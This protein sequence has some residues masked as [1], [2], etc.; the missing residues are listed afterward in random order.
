MSL[1]TSLEEIYPFLSV[2][3]DFELSAFMPYLEQATR[4]ELQALLGKE[5]LGALMDEYEQAAGDPQAMESKL[6]ALLL[7]VQR[8]LCFYAYVRFA[9]TSN[10]TLSHQGMFE[11]S[12]EHTMSA[13]KWKIQA[14]LLDLIA[15]GDE[16]A[17]SL[18][19]FLEEHA[20]DYPLWK[21][22]EAFSYSDGS[23][24]AKAEEFSHF[25]DINQS[26]R[27]FLRLKPYIRRAEILAKKVLGTE[28]FTDLH[29]QL[30]AQSVSPEGEELL[31]YVRAY[32]AHEAMLRALPFLSF[33][34]SASG[35]QII[36]TI[37]QINVKSAL[38][39]TDRKELK[40]EVYTQLEE[41]RR[42]LIQFLEEH[43]ANYP[44]WGNSAANSQRQPKTH[45]R[46]TENKP[47]RGYIGF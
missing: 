8:P 31:V 22:S 11:Q 35:L 41:A 16:A 44:L 21:D 30:S 26:R 4:K 6:A 34:Q 19:A 5:L 27:L 2:D 9:N 28:Q 25:I 12:P 39:A 18:I 20:D 23:L 13:P 47:D 10:L 37:E 29:A 32:V 43:A 17:E 45:W 46:R 15:Q 1:I 36:T 40:Q 33:S 42:D 7:W 3:A 14:L 24:F 38:S